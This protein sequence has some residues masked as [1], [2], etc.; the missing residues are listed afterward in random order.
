MAR[1]RLLAKRRH[2]PADLSVGDLHQLLN[3]RRWFFNDASIDIEDGAAMVEAWQGVESI[4]LPLWQQ[5][6]PGV[7]LLPWMRGETRRVT[8]DDIRHIVWPKTVDDLRAVRQLVRG[9]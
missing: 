2:N 3:G 5:H 9:G 7:P 4:L 8:Y 6:N 1:R